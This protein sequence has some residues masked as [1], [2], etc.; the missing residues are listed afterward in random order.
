MESCKH[1]YQ[2]LCNLIITPAFPSQLKHR[3][4]TVNPKGCMWDEHQETHSEYGHNSRSPHKRMHYSNR[5]SHRA[6]PCYN[7]WNRLML[8][9]HRGG[10]AHTHTSLFQIPQTCSSLI[11]FVRFRL[12]I[13]RA[14]GKGRDNLYLIWIMLM[15]YCTFCWVSKICST[16]KS[17]FIKQI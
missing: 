4:A 7:L 13:Y 16:L 8:L 5:S 11:T 6:L 14:W 1:C 3:I 2:S 15:L 10:H 17:Q 12:L 9:L